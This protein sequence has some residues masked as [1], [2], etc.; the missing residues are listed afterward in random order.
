M[1][2]PA[3]ESENMSTQVDEPASEET[4]QSMA[5]QIQDSRPMIPIDIAHID[6]LASANAADSNT[7]FKRKATVARSPIATN[8]SLEPDMLDRQ[9]VLPHIE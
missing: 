6:T 2:K 8:Y 4:K 1:S 9:K 5:S 3:T 7:S